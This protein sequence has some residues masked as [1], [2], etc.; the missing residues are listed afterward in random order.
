MKNKKWMNNGIIGAVIIAGCSAC[1]DTI[2]DHYNENSNVA[3]ETLWEIIK[4]AGYEPIENRS[5]VVS[6]ASSNLS[7]AIIK[8]FTEAKEFF[9]L[10][11]CREELVLVPYGKISWGLKKEVTM[12][13]PFSDIQKIEVEP[14]GLNYHLIIDTESGR[15][16]LSTQQKELS[17]FRSSGL[18]GYEG[19]KN[20]KRFFM[21][22]WH[23][24]NLDATLEALKAI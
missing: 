22:N 9:V 4:A 17:D 18:L 3:K 20:W 10:Q 7:D 14:A 12:S 16:T 24:E 8:F 1:T 13:I 6:Y 15:I 23:K 21:R 19:S 2:A 11:I 5:I